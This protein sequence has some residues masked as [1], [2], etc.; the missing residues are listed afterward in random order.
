MN[1]GN[2]IQDLR[3]KAGLSQDQLAEKLDVSRQSVSKWESG[4]CAPEID[5]IVA[6][7]DIF[8]VTT[9]WLLKG[10]EK[11]EPCYN[12]KENAVILESSPNGIDKN[13]VRRVLSSIAFA[14]I[15]FGTLLRVVGSAV[16]YFPPGARIHYRLTDIFNASSSE[17]Y[18]LT[19]IYLVTIG[20]VIFLVMILTI[21]RGAL[22]KARNI[23]IKR[24]GHVLTLSLTYSFLLNIFFIFTYNIDLTFITV[25]I[26]LCAAYGLL[27]FSRVKKKQAKQMMAQR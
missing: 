22:Q 19:G 21:K 3:K 2:R 17:T 13:N 23:Q 15:F 18:G 10:G 11:S 20:T 24:R 4:A 1:L 9:D 7:S 27:Y 12:K 16:F 26:L 6:I 5:K 14:W 8:G 25:Y